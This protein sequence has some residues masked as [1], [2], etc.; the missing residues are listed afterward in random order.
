MSKWTRTRRTDHTVTRTRGSSLVLGSF[1]LFDFKSLGDRVDQ[2]VEEFVR[3]LMQRA[4]EKLV[5]AFELV[6]K[7]LRGDGAE[8]ARLR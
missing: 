3:V 1:P 8:S 6:D 7:G 4:P 2:D 5:V